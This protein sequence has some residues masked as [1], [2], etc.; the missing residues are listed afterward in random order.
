MTSDRITRRTL[1]QGSALAAASIATDAAHPVNSRSLVVAPAGLSARERLLLDFGWRFHFGHADDPAKDFGYGKDQSTYAK[2]ELD[3]ADA[4]VAEFDD[5]AWRAIDLPHDW[6]V[7]LLPVPTVDPPRMIL[8][9]GTVSG[10]WD[11]NSRK[12]ASAG[13]GAVSNCLLPTPAAVFLWNSTGCSA[14]AS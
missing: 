6:A 11:G 10:H 5:S 2:S 4:A 12:T 14:I 13:I 7:E 8:A 3:V 1:L 9:P